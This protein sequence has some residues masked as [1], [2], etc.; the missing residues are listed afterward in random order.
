MANAKSASGYYYKLAVYHYKTA[1]QETRLDTYF[2]Q[3]Y[4]PALHRAGFKQIGVFKPVE[5]DTADK[6]IYVLIPASSWDKLKDVDEKLSSDN[7][8]TSAAADYTDAL[9][10]NA[11]YDRIETILLKA[12]T[13]MPVP[14]I[15]NLNGDKNERVYELRSYESA[16][17]KQHIN[18]VKM[19]NDGNEVALFNR[20]GFNAVF[21][22]DV[23]AGG[24]MPNLMYMTT[25]NNKADRDKHWDAFGSDAEWKEL[26]ARPEYQHNVSKNTIVFL[27]P[28]Q[29]S[30]F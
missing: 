14:A 4:L 18:K 19:F 21:Y 9:Y 30:D 6:K 20:L 24:H 12:F 25:F 2:Q 1:A 8:Y 5:Q 27:R 17:E 16:T 15:P 23:I 29:Y 11:P 13:K 10:N 7:T 22:G 3:A 26:S 28:A